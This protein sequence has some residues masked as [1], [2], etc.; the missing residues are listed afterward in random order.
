M[1]RMPIKPL[2]LI[3]GANSS[4]KSSIVHSLLLANHAGESGN[5]DV[6]QPRLAGGVVDLGGFASYVHGHDPTRA[7]ALGFD[8]T[9][10]KDGLREAL[11]GTD[12]EEKASFCRF[13]RFGLALS[14]GLPEATV[15][16]LEVRLDGTPALLFQR[17]AD[18]KLRAQALPA[19][20]DLLQHEIRRIVEEVRRG[21]RP[22]G[23]RLFD[24][25]WLGPGEEPEVERQ[26]RELREAEEKRAEQEFRSTFTASAEDLAKLR[27]TF[28]AVMSEDDFASEKL[29]LSDPRP[30]GFR[31]WNCA[32]GQ[33]LEY[34]SVLGFFREMDSI[35]DRDWGPEAQ[36]LR[37]NL[38]NLLRF[39]CEELARTLGETRYLGPLRHVPGRYFTGAEL[40]KAAAT[41]AAAAWVQLA[42]NLAV[43][44]DVNRW[45][46]SDGL[47]TRYS[48]KMRRILDDD[49][50]ERG[51][52]PEFLDS[53]TETR[54]SHRE[55]GFGISQVLPVLVEAAV[56]KGRLVAIEQPELH[57]HPA[58]QA[59]LGDVFIES[60]L[61]ER[62]NTFLLET[63]SE[64]LILR[65]LR[66]IRESTA[67]TTTGLPAIRPE[68][69]SVL[70]VQ[71]GPNGSE[72]IDLPVTPDGD[73]ER[74]WPKGF[75][76]E[77]F[78]DLP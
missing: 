35:D 30:C 23:R 25:Y 72:V 7:V 77:R 69:V 4:G 9:I 6:H 76:A 63:H 57:L 54:L 29:I 55:L 78:Q 27:E 21:T 48:L 73:F 41:Q 1:Q 75:F 32:M 36:A 45:L 13:S 14:W 58:Q 31:K 34:G 71:P 5:F 28:S 51:V 2:T 59:Q 37:F 39:C 12:E 43:V 19:C 33:L 3:F 49:G 74:P 18:A 67:G 16:Q 10:A 40:E 22:G 24:R 53:V 20:S 56:N 46:G 11:I 65:I 8:T 15:K 50:G 42:R 38:S 70:Y 61:G 60:A 62:K 68:N 66:R 52:F 17:T 26:K 44:E 47:K 64:H